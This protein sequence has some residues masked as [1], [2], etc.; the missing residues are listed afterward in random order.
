MCILIAI[1]KS[2]MIDSMYFSMATPASHTALHFWKR[3]MLFE[4]EAKIDTQ[5]G[6]QINFTVSVWVE[7]ILTMK[8][9]SFQLIV[10][11]L[12]TKA[13][14]VPSTSVESCVGNSLTKCK[15]SWFFV[16]RFSAASS[17][18]QHHA[19]T[20]SCSISVSHV[21]PKKP[22]SRSCQ[23]GG[24]RILSWG[25]QSGLKQKADFCA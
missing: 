13:S 19:P 1:N 21:I 22:A 12:G 23:Q 8:Q 5:D 18:M 9:I 7:H 6:P 17:N 16:H 14:T 15:P 24:G 4:R 10:N 25:L 11:Y 20:T 2:W 3:A